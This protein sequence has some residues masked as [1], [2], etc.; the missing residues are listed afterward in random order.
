VSTDAAHETRSRPAGDIKLGYR[1]AGCGPRVV[2][3]HG[4]GQDH[5]IWG[6][7]QE[8]LRDH[9]TLAYDLRGHGA[10]TLGDALGTVDQLGQD[11]IALLEW[12]GPATLVGFSLGGVIALWVA[13][14]R[15]DLVQ[16]VIAV[17]T[18]SVVGRTAADGLDERIALFERGERTEIERQLL[19]D[20]R[21]QLANSAVDAGAVAA[22]RVAAI[23]DPAGYANAARAVRRMRGEPLNERLDRIALPVL[24]VAGERDGW[25]PRRAA[26]IMLEHLSHASF[27]ELDGVGHLM[28]ED[29]PDRLTAVVRSWLTNTEV[30]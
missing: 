16:T 29:A 15:P 20:T 24:V 7:M 27:I 10:S 3:I 14:E 17:A 19:E 6:A 18:S 21:S 12:F 22:K 4:L 2:F 9:Q 1:V 30:E 5:A 13:S 25:C 28:T 26:E 8:E 23:V 11:L